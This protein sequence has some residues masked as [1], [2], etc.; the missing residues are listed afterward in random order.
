MEKKIKIAIYP[1][2]FDPLTNGHVDI[3]NRA[4]DLF[5]RLIIT[6]ATNN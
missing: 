1:G 6:V 4:S 2:S 3:I 5:N